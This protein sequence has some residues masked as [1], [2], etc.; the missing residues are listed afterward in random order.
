MHK[1]FVPIYRYFHSHKTLM[2]VILAVTT[3][4]FIFFGLKVKYEEDITKL[5]PTSSVESQLAFG[6]IQ[7]KDKIYM[8]VTSAEEPLSPQVLSERMDEFTDLLFER[9]S[10]THFIS[11][12]LY[13]MEPEVA[14][15]ALDFVLEHIPSFIDTSAYR[16][17]EKALEPETIEKQ[18]WVN[19]EQMM[20]DEAG[21]L[22]QA[23]AY[24]PLNLR[25]VV[26][27]D[28]LLSAS[29]SYNII[30]GHLFCP[31]STVAIAYLAPAFRSLDS[32][33]ST[34][35]SKMLSRAQ[36]D[37]ELMYPDVKVHTHGDPIGSVSNAGRIRSDLVVTVGISLILIFIL[38]GLCFRS[39]QFLW[40]LLLPIIYGTAFSLACIYWLKGGMSL[41]AL[42]LGAIILGVAIS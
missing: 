4:I 8:Q 12:I 32:R 17:F 21:D 14:I 5:L 10:S 11:N 33:A 41:M 38:I 16:D 37:F 30:D 34:D 19:Y 29:S 6:S 26:L 3:L 24:D 15:N 35:F 31:D 27:G 1:I 40:E 36:K 9:D 22:T 2:Y 20:E 25:G 28:V 39:L 7:L 13:K 18:M 42:G 23:I